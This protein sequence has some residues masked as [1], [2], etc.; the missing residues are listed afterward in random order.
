MYMPFPV[1]ILNHPCQS[2]LPN[3]YNNNIFSYYPTL[4][5]RSHDNEEIV[6]NK[7]S[8]NIENQR[9]R[10]SFNSISFEPRFQMQQT[11][12]NDLAIGVPSKLCS[13]CGDISTGIHFGGNSCESCKAFF[14]RSVQCHRY[15]NYKCSGEE[16]CPVNI[17]TRKVCQFCRYQKCTT[18]GMKSKWVL[19]D[20]EREEKYGARRK[21]FRENRAIDEDPD[22]YKFLT[23]EEKLL[24]EDIAHA[25]YQSRATYPLSFPNPS[26][27]FQNPSKSSSDNTNVQSPPSEKPASGPANFLI[28]PIQRL[29]LFARMLKD[30]DLF[31]EDDKV[32]L[33]KGSA[34]DIMVCSS[35]T[36]FDPKTHT[37]TNYLSR[38]QRAL[39]DEQILPLD[40]LL[41]KLWG[42]EIFTRTRSYL[43]SMCNLRVDEVTSTLLVPVILFS[44]DRLNIKDIDLVKR[45]QEKYATILRKYMNWRYGVE[46]TDKIYPKLLLQI[47]S[48]RSLSLAHGEIIQKFIAT[49]DVNPLVQEI[50]IKP[51]LFDRST[52]EKMDSLSLS[53]S[54]SD[55]DMLEFNKLYSNETESNN[56]SDEDDFA[57]K[58]SCPSNDTMDFDND[59][60]DETDL[61]NIWRKRRKLSNTHQFSS[62]MQTDTRTEQNNSNNT[63]MKNTNNYKN[64][65]KY[66]NTNCLY[67]RPHDHQVPTILPVQHG[68]VMVMSNSGFPIQNQFGQLSKEKQSLISSP[69][70]MQQFYQTHSLSPNDLSSYDYQS[71]LSSAYNPMPS[72]TLGHEYDDQLYENYR[73]HY[74]TMPTNYQQQQTEQQFGYLSLANNPSPTP[75]V[76]SLTNPQSQPTT[77]LPTG[78]P[79]DENE[80]HLLNI[81]QADPHKRDLVLNLLR[82]M[83]QS[84]STQQQQQH[85]D[86]PTD[87]QSQRKRSNKESEDK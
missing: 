77:N 20:Q 85:T 40:P 58:K 38:D 5:R 2:S 18:I 71:Q 32:S 13:V 39:M 21:R 36:L 49:S 48:I 87:H 86:S 15:Q 35:N 30:F 37:F 12:V 69:H 82:Q 6:G 25:L 50:T 14:R 78:T 29:V 64:N 28:V 26:A 83:S 1:P 80:Q 3:E 17:V 10:R 59:D 51:E 72:P 84:S 52:T 24:I 61:H 53:S 8:N 81:I 23:K 33:L 4:K 62:T 44:P 43:I 27:L 16:N 66:S 55:T 70:S 42:E 19:S 76:H 67:M 31:T 47:I 7:L 22:I 41:I 75:S 46:H 79:L 65:N 60:F 68:D 11:T 56:G 45:L 54:P 57:K 73:D 74:T 9:K 34:I 63:Q